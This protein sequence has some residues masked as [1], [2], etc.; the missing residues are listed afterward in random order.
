MAKL[1]G[2]KNK[3]SASASWSMVRKKLCD[4]LNDAKNGN[5]ASDNA[6]TS[7]DTQ[8]ENGAIADD[9]GSPP[10]ASPKKKAAR[11][12]KATVENGEEGKAAPA[13]KR[14][15]APKD[16]NAVPAKRAKKEKVDWKEAAKAEADDEDAGPAPDDDEDPKPDSIFGNGVIKTE[17]GEEANEGDDEAM[18]DTV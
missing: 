9:E 5:A 6:T 10:A 14:S 16:P 3:N 18:A 7:N 8:V 4:G 1:G 11:K 13:K 2:F 17:E 15:R 12:P